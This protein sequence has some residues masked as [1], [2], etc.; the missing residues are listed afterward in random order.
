MTLPIVV[1]LALVIETVSGESLPR[2]LASRIFEPLGMDATFVL[3]SPSQKAADVARG[4]DETGRADDFEGIP[5]FLHGDAYRM[6]PVRQ[7][8][9]ARLLDRGAQSGGA[10]RRPCAGDDTSLRIPLA[11][12]AAAL[13]IRRQPMTQFPGV[14]RV[15]RLLQLGEAFPAL[16]THVL[17]HSEQSGAGRVVGTLD[18]V[19]DE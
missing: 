2:I 3:T 18:I 11:R 13:P 6:Q 7:I 1:L 10:T 16:L 15:D 19:Q 9:G 14:E 5:Q 12:Y 4:Y 8:H 17:L